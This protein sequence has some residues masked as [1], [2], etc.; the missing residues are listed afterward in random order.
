MQKYS[1]VI[2]KGAS[3][4]LRNFLVHKI[5]AVSHFE[6]AVEKRRSSDQTP[7][8]SAE[9]ADGHAHHEVKSNVAGRL[10]IWQVRLHEVQ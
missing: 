2:R 9:Y 10:P 6:A 4:M 3:R 8:R 7:K 1:D 5:A